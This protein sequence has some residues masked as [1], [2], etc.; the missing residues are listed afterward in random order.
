ME[1]TA[2]EGRPLEAIALCEAHLHRFAPSA[3][4]W[5][6]LG[7]LRDSLSDPD[8][9]ECYR[10]ALYL[11]PNHYESLLQMAALSEKSG[12]AS[13]AQ[14]FRARAARSKPGLL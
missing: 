5:H 2:G 1:K 3:K 6:L 4:V 11:E 12:D 8:A 7:R 10:R 13:R 9:R 14:T